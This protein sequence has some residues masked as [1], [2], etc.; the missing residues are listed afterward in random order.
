MAYNARKAAMKA[1]QAAQQLDIA[2][3][4][5]EHQIQ[6]QMQ[7]QQQQQQ[8][9]QRPSSSGPRPMSGIDSAQRVTAALPQ[10]TPYTKAWASRPP[11]MTALNSTASSSS[12]SATASSSSRRLVTPINSSTTSPVP[13]IVQPFHQRAPPTRVSSTSS[14]PTQMAT[15]SCSASSNS[16]LNGHTAGHHHHRTHTTDVPTFHPGSSAPGIVNSPLTNARRG[17][18]AGLVGPNAKLTSASRSSSGWSLNNMMASS[19]VN[20]NNKRDDTHFRS[21]ELARSGSGAGTYVNT[22]SGRQ[23]AVTGCDDADEDDVDAYASRYPMAVS[24][25][26]A[27][28]DSGIHSLST[29]WPRTMMD[30]QQGGPSRQQV[31]SMRVSRHQQFRDV[32]S[33]PSSP[34]S[35]G[36]HLRNSPHPSLTNDSSNQSSPDSQLCRTPS[37]APS[38]HRPAH[39]R[40]FSSSMTVRGGSK[41]MPI[42]GAQDRYQVAIE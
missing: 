19:H 37:P 26:P 42:R 23:Y 18:K 25:G 27:V 4:E 40:S 36:S 8:Q 41:P 28:D 39:E 11:S 13:G 16:H 15:L 14:V 31:P 35:T 32:Q 21:G 30:R 5:Q 12:S 22:L 1:Q 2:R 24:P 10:R 7:L 29:T 9:A 6:F 38:F 33:N 3:R 17:S 34:G 20:N